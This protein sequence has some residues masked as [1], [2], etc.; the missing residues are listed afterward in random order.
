MAAQPIEKS[1]FRRENPRKAKTIQRWGAGVFGAK[2]PSAKK[3]QAADAVA[4]RRSSA[5]T[6]D[7]RR[8]CAGVGV[9]RIGF[10]GLDWGRGPGTDAIA[11]QTHQKGRLGRI[12]PIESGPDP[13][14]ARG[15]EGGGDQGD[16]QSGRC[17]ATGERFNSLGVGALS[18]RALPS[19][20]GSA[21][22]THYRFL[23]QGQ[24]KF[25]I[26]SFRI[27]NRVQRRRRCASGPLSSEIWGS[28]KG[29]CTKRDISSKPSLKT[30]RG[31]RRRRSPREGRAQKLL[32]DVQ[33]EA[34][35]CFGLGIPTYESA[36]SRQAGGGF[37]MAGRMTGTVF[38]RPLAKTLGP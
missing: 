24:K 6:Q 16:G 9:S 17:L 37:A 29:D 14:S 3:T 5:V 36:L 26:A 18:S 7:G 32:P 35:H 15:E 4:R 12:Q 8:H 1:S 21:V 27:Q 2:G 22:K 19:G 31:R 20:S 30:S 10:H 23:G 28:R 34:E 33:A 11:R 25:R 38:R 13:R